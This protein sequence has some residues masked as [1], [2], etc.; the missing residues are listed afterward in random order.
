MAEKEA[1]KDD[2]SQEKKGESKETAI[3]PA[4][5]PAPQAEQAALT[6]EQKDQG[7]RR[8]Q[9]KIKLFCDKESDIVKG[10]LQLHWDRGQ[11]VDEL[12]SGPR[13]Y[14][15]HTA[16]QFG[17]DVSKDKQNPYKADTVRSWHRFYQRYSAKQLQEAVDQ[18]VPWRAIQ[19]LTAIDDLKKRE[20]VQLQ[21]CKH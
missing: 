10:V 13:N 8:Y 14:N 1:M 12:F 9:E 20:D 3:V 18:R 11:F 4:S 16:E 15:N 6:K 19:V 7:E 5:A 17:I 21:I 2:K